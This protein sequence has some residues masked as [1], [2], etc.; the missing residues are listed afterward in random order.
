[1]QIEACRHFGPVTLV[2]SRTGLQSSSRRYVR[3][4]KW[5]YTSISVRRALSERPPLITSPRCA[6]THCGF[7]AS[8]SVID[9]AKR[10]PVPC[11]LASDC[12]APKR[13][14]PRC[15]TPQRR[16]GRVHSI[17]GAGFASFDSGHESCPLRGWH[18]ALSACEPAMVRCRV[19][20]GAETRF[21]GFQSAWCANRLSNAPQ[22]TCQ[23]V[24]KLS[25]SPRTTMTMFA[26]GHRQHPRCWGP[27]AYVHMVYHTRCYM[28][29]GYYNARSCYPHRLAQSA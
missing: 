13:L 27:M 26:I 6:C 19:C 17:M 22:K 28:C 4:L 11:M 18:S 23:R 25:C 21:L 14:R 8:F 10:P 9:L 16:R 3:S 29:P 2:Q 1:V 12:Q 15:S 24:E 7:L 5:A 20:I